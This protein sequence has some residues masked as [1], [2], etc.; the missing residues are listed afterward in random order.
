MRTG[1]RSTE[2][3]GFPTVVSSRHLGR[4]A[5]MPGPGGAAQAGRTDPWPTVGAPTIHR[6]TRL[7]HSHPPP[8]PP[9]EWPLL[10]PRA[11]PDSYA[12]SVEFI[13]VRHAEPLQVQVQG[14]ADP[15]LS[16]AGSAQAAALGAAPTLGAVDVI[17][18]SPARRAVDTVAPYAR[19][20][21]C[22]QVT[23]EAMAEWDWGAPDYVPFEVLRET[24]DPRY[25]RLIAGEPY[26]DVDMPAFRRRVVA[27]FADLAAANPGRRRVLV[28]THAGVI[29]AYLG[30][31][32][33]IDRP[34]WF[35]PDYTSISRVL[36]SRDG[37]RGVRSVNETPHLVWAAARADAVSAT[38]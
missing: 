35:A 34:L 33:G 37:R 2:P 5:R 19:R 1:V 30:D 20:A 14:V 25:A 36:V 38:R 3:R 22:A 17:V 15:G 24:N 7:A 29:N 9:A 21:G 23:V 32:L 4:P 28:T 18:Q 27:A 12:P 6:A 10:T 13:L 26:A 31:V 16:E 8:P 11:G